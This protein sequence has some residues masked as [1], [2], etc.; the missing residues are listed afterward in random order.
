MRQVA[1]IS[2]GFCIGVLGIMAVRAVVEILIL[3]QLSSDAEGSKL[4]GVNFYVMGAAMLAIPSG[5]AMAVVL[6]PLRAELSAWSNR[7]ALTLG[8]ILGVAIA[9][10][11]STGAFSSL[12]R[13]LALD[14]SLERWLFRASPGVVAAAIAILVVLVTRALRWRRRLISAYRG[15]G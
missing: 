2:G 1:R 7:L 6:F 10:F 5:I 11:V 15:G 8:T 4:I 13:Q 12:G 3:G 9:V 14:G